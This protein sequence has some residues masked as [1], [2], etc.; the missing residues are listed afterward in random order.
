MR[1]NFDRRTGTDRT[2][3][4][5][6]NSY[7]EAEELAGSNETIMVRNSDPS[8]WAIV[9]YPDTGLDNEDDWEEDDRR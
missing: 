8:L 4:L 3:P 6:C 1:K 9:N 5:F 7:Q 2:L